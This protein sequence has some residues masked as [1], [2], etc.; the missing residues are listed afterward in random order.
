MSS[1]IASDRRSPRQLRNV[2]RTRPCVYWRR[3]ASPPTVGPAG[4]TVTSDDLVVTVVIPPDALQE[5]IPITVHP[6]TDPPPAAA[7][8]RVY[9]IEPFGLLFEKLVTITYAYGA[10]GVADPSAVA[11]AIFGD[12]KPVAFTSSADTT[13][14]TLSAPVGHLGPVG[15]VHPAPLPSRDAVAS[16]IK[17]AF[18]PAL[19]SASV[20]ATGPMTVLAAG[21]TVSDKY[22]SS[23]FDA[24]PATPIPAPTFG[25]PT[26]FTASRPTWFFWVDLMP[27]APAT[28]P[29]VYLFVDP[30]TGTLVEQLGQWWPVVDGA[31]FLFSAADRAASPLTAY[32]P[33]PKSDGLPPPSAASVA[34]GAAGQAAAGETWPPDCSGALVVAFA[35]GANNATDEVAFGSGADQ[36]TTYAATL[37]GPRDITFVPVSSGVDVIHYLDAHVVKHPGCYCDVLIYIIGHGQAGA[38]MLHPPSESPGPVPDEYARSLYYDDFAVEIAKIVSKKTAIVIDSCESGTFNDAIIKRQKIAK[39]PLKC[40][41]W[42]VVTAAKEGRSE[43]GSVSASVK[44]GG[45]LKLTE[46]WMSA[47]KG[48]NDD[49]WAGAATTAVGSLDPWMRWSSPTR[50]DYLCKEAKHDAIKLLDDARAEATSEASRGDIVET[51]LG[52][53]R[54]SNDVM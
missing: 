3:A 14:G 43:F 50:V 25:P 4:G 46:A 2:E 54:I 26:V 27:G 6:S 41:A 35:R 39:N 49:N 48:Q 7:V 8:G 21:E 52:N 16:V 28:H 17:G 32:A 36:I 10:A 37:P 34:P 1:H 5:E 30:A 40:V 45:S 22:G 29:S 9:V 12:G 19:W 23:T 31:E 11:L 20:M 38:L 47:L 13:A 44:L 15:L 53:G 51:A 33:D 18:V 42:T 24:D